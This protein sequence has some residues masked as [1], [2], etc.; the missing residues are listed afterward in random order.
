[1]SSSDSSFSSSLAAAGSSAAAAA[2]PAAA[3]PAAGAAP[4]PEPP[5]G[6]EANFSVPAEISYLMLTFVACATCA[7]TYLIDIL[8]LEFFQE[9]G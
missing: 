2:P 7:L 4:P 9:L 1:M 3:P 5:D 8:A 6:T